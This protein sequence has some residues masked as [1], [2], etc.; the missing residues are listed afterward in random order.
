MRSVRTADLIHPDDA[1][2]ARRRWNKA[3][4]EGIGDDIDYRIRASD[5]AYRWQSWRINPVL[6][7]G[8]SLGWTGVGIDTEEAKR[9]QIALE[10]SNAQLEQANAV[11]DAFLAL[12]SHELRTPL[13]TIAGLASLLVRRFDLLD[14]DE[15]RTS[16]AQLHSDATRLAEIIENL[17][18]LARLDKGALAMEP[19]L[20]HRLVEQVVDSIKSRHPGRTVNFE[21]GR[22][23]PAVIGEPTLL[24]LVIENLVANA[25]KY[26][27]ADSSIEVRVDA[28]E[29]LA[30][31][32]SDR[33]WGVSDADQAN[34]FEPFFRSA[35]ALQSGAPGVGLGLAVCRR[36]IDLHGGTITFAPRPGGGSVFQFTIPLFDDGG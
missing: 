3:L 29:H 21:G 17:L 16:L 34:V 22:T 25:I 19:V 1:R 11:K 5:G 26:S 14:D 12:V 28:T 36:L 30:I 15:R 10:E 23:F 4:R 35:Q 18:V 9:L 33:G 6:R 8:V 27:P 13:T 24:R 20:V 32:V 7:D 2:E 31:S